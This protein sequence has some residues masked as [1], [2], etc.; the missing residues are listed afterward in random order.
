VVDKFIASGIDCYPTYTPESTTMCLE[1]PTNDPDKRNLSVASTAGS[2]TSKEIEHL[3]AKSAVIGTSFR[4]EAGNDV[5]QS[6]KSK[7]VFLAVDMQ[8][9]ARVLLGEKLVYK[10]WGEMNNILPYIDVLKCDA[11]EA[12][13]ITGESNFYHAAEIFFRM[14]AKEVVLSHKDGILLLADGK[15]TAIDFFPENL[16]GRSGRGDTCIGSYMAMRITL[17]PC[18]SLIWA[19]AVTSLKMGKLGPFDRSLADV[20][21][22]IE[23]HYNH[24]N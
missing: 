11:V 1:Y 14:G 9:F 23:K 6:F 2:I 4:G 8:G 22:F 7:N 5:I 12:R 15:F 21:Q 19:A 10:P 24:K 16:I 18:E 17:D 3:N 20:E 13:S